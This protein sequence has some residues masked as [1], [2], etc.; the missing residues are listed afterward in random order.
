MDRGPSLAEML[1]L[2]GGKENVTRMIELASDI[3]SASYKATIDV[4]KKS[5]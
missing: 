5:Q 3:H 4:V 2:Q 1:A